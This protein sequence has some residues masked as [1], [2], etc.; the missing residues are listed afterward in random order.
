MTLASLRAR[1]NAME[2]SVD[3][4]SAVTKQLLAC[5]AELKISRSLLRET[6]SVMSKA[7]VS[8]KV[9]HT[10]KAESYVFQVERDAEAGL[11]VRK[12]S[13]ASRSECLRPKIENP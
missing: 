8:E 9:A 12:E 3:A 13:C 6:E 7:S 4:A 5:E 2:R 11:E 1:A 10:I